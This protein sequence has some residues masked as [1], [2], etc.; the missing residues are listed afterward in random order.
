MRFSI[1]SSAFPG[2]SGIGDTFSLAL[3][4]KQKKICIIAIAAFALLAAAYYFIRTLCKEKIVPADLVE[5]KKILDVVQV[6]Q[7]KMNDAEPPPVEVLSQEIPLVEISQTELSVSPA[8]KERI[9]LFFADL[10]RDDE[11]LEKRFEELFPEKVFTEEEVL[12]FV[13]CAREKIQTVYN[14]DLFAYAISTS[15]IEEMAKLIQDEPLS[16]SEELRAALLL[17]YCLE[18]NLSVAEVV[19]EMQNAEIKMK[20][21]LYKFAVHLA[22]Q[23]GAELCEEI[24]SFNLDSEDLQKIADRVLYTDANAFLSN[25]NEFGFHEDVVREEYYLR[26]LIR[27]VDAANVI[28]EDSLFIERLRDLSPD[29]LKTIYQHFKF[30][31]SA[32]ESCKDEVKDQR[33]EDEIFALLMQKTYPELTVLG[34]KNAPL[35]F[36][37]LPEE[38]KLS[39]LSMI[40]LLLNF[41]KPEEVVQESDM[42]NFLNDLRN[43][44][45]PNARFAA[46]A[47]ILKFEREGK[48]YKDIFSLKG[49]SKKNPMY[50]ALVIFACR[51]LCP[52]VPCFSKTKMDNADF[53]K[54]I[55]NFLAELYYAEELGATGKQ[56]LLKRILE[57]EELQTAKKLLQFTSC[58]RRG[59]IQ[60]LIKGDDPAII[61]ADAL[62]P[63]LDSLGE[64]YNCEISKELFVKLD[65]IVEEI[66]Y[67]AQ[68]LE[69]LPQEHKDR[70]I[71]LFFRFLT[72]TAEGKMVEARYETEELQSIFK[73]YSLD[74]WKKGS[75]R[76][77]AELLK[78]DPDFKM[79]EDKPLNF[80]NELR[81]AFENEHLKKEEYP[82]FYRAAFEESRRNFPS[83]GWSDI[84]RIGIKG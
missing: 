21:Q 60:P 33:G 36:D 23:K 69:R 19:I 48:G 25:L 66:E 13:E 57:N 50:C 37:Q 45:D 77:V 17:S 49:N 16:F 58:I 75:H 81:I 42:F 72:L 46:V 71:P 24:D 2:F 55:V 35:L 29:V 34:F 79:M 31:K 39:L 76:S 83:A 56:A 63:L 59:L 78:D 32:V 28:L 22:E 68:A 1:S 54:N 62:K 82:D 61:M 73:S 41:K 11:E 4:S 26:G 18:K 8:F 51:H 20:N 30:G 14:A 47:M 67:Y 40:L 10:L 65:C 7:P 15:L 27:S 53:I 84:K 52:D 43:L 64:P 12:L 6:A 70:M 74:L 38:E 5:D 80:Q 9:D 3:T 44:N